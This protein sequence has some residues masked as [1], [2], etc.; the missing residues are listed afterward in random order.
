[1]ACICAPEN[2]QFYQQLFDFEL[3]G[4]ASEQVMPRDS[5][6]KKDDEVVHFLKIVGNS[7]VGSLDGVFVMTAPLTYY[8]SS[9]NGLITSMITLSKIFCTYYL[10]DI[11]QPF[12]NKL[13]ISFQKILD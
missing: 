11:N 5:L 12:M 9:T 3:Q 8:L 13:S 7:F 2:L 4:F 10:N 6:K 1:M